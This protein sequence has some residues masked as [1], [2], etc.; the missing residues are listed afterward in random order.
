MTMDGR[1]MRKMQRMGRAIIQEN[2]VICGKVDAESSLLS[3]SL[4]HTH[5]QSHRERGKLALELRPAVLSGCAWCLMRQRDVKTDS[6]NEM[7]DGHAVE[8]EKHTQMHART[9]THTQTE[10]ERDKEQ[11]C[12]HIQRAKAM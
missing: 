5:T 10:R 2:K 6:H 11:N 3:L 9:H 1:Q 7:A 4:T 8:K 12:R